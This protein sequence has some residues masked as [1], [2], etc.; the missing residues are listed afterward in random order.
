MS[1][2]I[3][4]ANEKGGVAKT[5]T[6]ISLGAALAETGCTVLLVDLDA[7][8]N[9]TMALNTEKNPDTPSMANVLLEGVPA[10][11]ALRQTQIARL[12]ILPSNAE[13]GLAERFLPI[14]QAYETTLTRI[15][16]GEKWEFDFILMDC[17]PFLGAV[18]YN[19]MMASDL[20]I[21]PTQAEYFSINGLRNMMGVI[22]RIR[23]QGNSRLT[24]RLLLT[25][26][27]RRN[28]IHHSMSE[29]LRSTFGAGVLETVIETDTKLRESPIAGVPIMVHAPKTRAALQYRA[30][31]QEIL[32]YVK[33]TASQPD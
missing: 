4:I 8:A 22:R 11:S 3:T 15:F 26:F 1:F 33:E 28:R 29:Q 32:K 2:I 13:L 7:Q 6:T 5:T 30:L 18:S 25:M 23:A 31:A 20:L 21:L 17:P 12:Q 16:R 19:A 9:L 27:D 14:R 24:Y 10:R